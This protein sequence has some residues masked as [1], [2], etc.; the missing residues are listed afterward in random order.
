MGTGVRIRT[1]TKLSTVIGTR[2]SASSKTTRW[3]GPLA[4]APAAGAAAAGGAAA[5]GG[6]APPE[7]PSAAPKA[8]S[9]KTRARFRPCSVSAGKTGTSGRLFSRSILLSA[10]KY[11]SRFLVPRAAAADAWKPRAEL[12]TP[13]KGPD[14]DTTAKDDAHEDAD[15]DAPTRRARC[16]ADETRCMATRGEGRGWER[17][18]NCARC[19]FKSEPIKS[20]PSPSHLPQ[21]QKKEGQN[22]AAGP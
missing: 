11:Q 14:D 21:Q 4:A 19:C 16:A 18:N 17:A 10:L 12:R 15:A 9:T 13:S 2:S 3:V 20:S 6:G 1:C 7:P 22:A 5:P 8:T